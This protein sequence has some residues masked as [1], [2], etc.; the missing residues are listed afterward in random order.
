[1]TTTL[2]NVE[3]R[4]IVDQAI[5]QIDYSIYSLEIDVLQAEA[6]SP[7]EEDLITSCNDRITKFNAKRVAL[8]AELNTITE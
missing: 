1:M 3:K 4:S 6:V 2:S 8:V 7:I 5:R